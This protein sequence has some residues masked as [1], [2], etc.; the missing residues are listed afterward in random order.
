MVGDRD[1]HSL[2]HAI[3]SQ[4]RLLDGGSTVMAS[5][6]AMLLEKGLYGLKPKIGIADE[7]AKLLEM[8]EWYKK[9]QPRLTLVKAALT[10]QVV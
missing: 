6:L 7:M 3:F 9:H 10:S 8:L 2:P 4:A 5:P 1:G